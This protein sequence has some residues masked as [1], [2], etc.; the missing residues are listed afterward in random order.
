MSERHGL[1]AIGGGPAA[2]AAARAYRAAGGRGAVALVADEQ[3]IPYQR[4]PLT[5]QL[6]RGEGDERELPLESEQWLREHGIA[7][8]ATRALALDPAARRVALA[9]GRELAY[10]RCLLAT[11]AEPVRLP[12]PGADDP[13]V[14]VLRT[15]HQLH[16]LLARLDAGAPVVVIG[17]G[18]IGCEAAASLRRRG[19]PVTLVSAEP[20]PLAARLGDAV[21][22]RLRGWLEQE[23]VELVV[24]AE[25]ERIEHGEQ[26]A[27]VVAG[28]RRCSGAVVLMA[29]GMR[30]RAEL[31]RAAGI[32][33]EEGAV[34]VDV[35][36]RTSAGSVLAAGDVCR[37]E[38][39]FAGRRLR[40]EHW[41]DALAHGE[42]AGRTAAGA[43]A[44]WEAVP[45]F[46]ST[47]GDRTLKH[48]AWGD[49]HAEVELRDHPDGGFTASYRDAAGRLVGVL[50]HDADDDYERGRDQIVADAR[51]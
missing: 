28:G 1:L 8:V 30:P 33:L 47:I 23:G 40:V 18:F 42:I 10:E 12:V 14:R 34:A 43:P 21:A 41:G 48:A 36:M 7:L 45:G 3:T 6:L 46:W 38:H 20:A 22:A 19:N 2:L 13:R 31:A 37:A 27:E 15:R 35:T 4:P 50:A 32:V 29:A 5:K 9:D 49:G 39:A 25:V 51:E 26:L 24:D 16:Q 11:G 44:R 17:S